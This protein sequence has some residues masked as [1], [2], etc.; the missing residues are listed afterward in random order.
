MANRIRVCCYENSEQPGTG[1]THRLSF[2]V[3]TQ[4]EGSPN[5]DF[6]TDTPV[7]DIT[8]QGVDGEVASRYEVGKEYHLDIFNVRST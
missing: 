8:L 1:G 3:S 2:R 5:E 7:G 4:T 6:F